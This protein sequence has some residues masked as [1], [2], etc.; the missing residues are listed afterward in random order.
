MTSTTLAQNGFP[1]AT[2]REPV[3]HRNGAAAVEMIADGPN[4]RTPPPDERHALALFCF[5][6]PD[7]FV[8]GQVRRLL[9]ALARRGT[10]VH[11]FAQHDFDEC[12]DVTVHTLGMCDGA[13]LPEQV[14]EFTHRAANAFLRCFPTDGPPVTLLGFEW[15]TAPALSL[16]HGVRHLPAVQS[17]HSLERQRSDLTG[18]LARK[19]DEI[20]RQ[21]LRESRAVLF[22][23]AASAEIAKYWVPEVGNRAVAARPPFPV[24]RFETGL[25][26][27]SVKARF[28]VGPVDPTIV[29]VG[30]LSDPYGQDLVVKAMPGILKNHQQ[31]R[32]IVVGDG[33]IYWPLRVYTRYLL[34]EHAVRLPGHMEGQ[35]L[36]ELTAAADMIVVPSRQQ[37]PWW[38]ILAGWAAGRPVVATHNAAPGLLEHEQDAVLCYPSENSLVWGVE[39]VLYDAE[40]RKNLAERGRAKLEERFGWNI[41]AEQVQEIMGV[42]KPR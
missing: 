28:Q 26:P 18:E 16:L 8:G 3:V 12:D 30:D 5:D 37:T 13:G 17:F 36:A 38:P 6:S 2:E 39:R 21:A 42:T 33:S 19:I 22:H 34:L 15:P 31:A 9:P 7:G 25:D 40:L 14:E 24:W 23:D 20:E 29:C 11:V 1:I 35:A 4:Y 10:P 27:A 41:L 32:L